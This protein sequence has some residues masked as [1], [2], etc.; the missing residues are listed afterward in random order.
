MGKK[1]L[2]K[3]SEKCEEEKRNWGMKDV[4]YGQ[5]RI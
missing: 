2:E 5:G 3:R 1:L 4:E